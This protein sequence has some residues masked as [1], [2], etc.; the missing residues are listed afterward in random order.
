MK[1]II[2]IKDEKVNVEEIMEK[3][4]KRIEEK[5][6][7]GL[8]DDKDIRDIEEMELKL[9]PDAEEIV[10][11]YESHLYKDVEKAVAEAMLNSPNP[12]KRFI[13]RRAA[14]KIFGPIYRFLYRNYLLE[15]QMKRTVHYVR[16][17]HNLS[18]NMVAELSKLRVKHDYLEMKLKV[19]EEKLALLEN[20]FRKYEE[21]Q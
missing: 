16:L 4:R 12:V 2:E 14:S 13:A 21:R 9:S 8:F 11:F 3:I 17:L 6:A 20:R 10:S 15:E 7:K 1:D 18:H 19:M 5:K